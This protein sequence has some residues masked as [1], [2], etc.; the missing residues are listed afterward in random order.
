MKG[1]T[2]TE[3]LLAWELAL[4]RQ[5][6]ERALAILS[7]A[8]DSDSIADLATLPIG[9]RD[10]RLRALRE[11]TF[12]RRYRALVSCRS[13]N[14]SLELTFEPPDFVLAEN[15]D[16]NAA[17]RTVR[18]GEYALDIRP[19]DS[20]DLAAA[21][22]CPDATAARRVLALRSVRAARRGDDGVP[23]DTIPDALLPDLAAHIEA[24][25]PEAETTHEV[26]CS[27]C[28]A[29]W[30]AAFDVAAYLWTEIEAEALRLL[31]QVHSLAGRY[32]WREADILAMSPLR[33]RAYL[34]LV[35]A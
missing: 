20:T 14:E 4:V 35:Q 7:A 8:E 25:D 17:S 30:D 32:G 6:A 2:P 26:T 27:A 22:R 19:L 16:A 15:A 18:L 29:R 21:A 5:P 12:G 1:L 9:S 3:L 13:C 28:G 24:I 33:R 31:Q 10:A 23:I 11:A 34:E